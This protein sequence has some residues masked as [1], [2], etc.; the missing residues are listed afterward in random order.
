MTVPVVIRANVRTDFD[1][2]LP[3]LAE[4]VRAELSGLGMTLQGEVRRRM[5]FDLGEEREDVE[6]N[7]KSGGFSLSVSGDKI[8][9]FIDEN[10]RRAGAKMPPWKKGTKLYKWVLRK[11]LGQDIQKG[12]RQFIHGKAARGV[13]QLLGKGALAEHNKMVERQV[14]ST[15]FLVAR[16]IAKRGIPAMKPFERTFLTFRPFIIRRVE[17]AINAAVAKINTGA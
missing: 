12:Q 15:S 6:W 8:Q 4:A 2:A 5:R 14:E 7:T 10:G 9:T 16:A 13:G 17:T 1:S 3:V 11:G